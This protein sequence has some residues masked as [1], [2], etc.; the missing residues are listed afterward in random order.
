MSNT[1]RYR[2]TALSQVLRDQGRH[3]KWLASRVGMTEATLSRVVNGISR[4]EAGKAGQIAAILGVPLFLV[5]E[6][7][8]GSKTDAPERNA[9]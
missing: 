7:S 2:A 9:A 3:Q 5:F 1:K 4:I 6:L 8:D